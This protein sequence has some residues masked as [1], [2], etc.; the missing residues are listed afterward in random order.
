LQEDEKDSCTCTG[1]ALATK[2]F[3]VLLDKPC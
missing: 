1:E 3:F 2:S